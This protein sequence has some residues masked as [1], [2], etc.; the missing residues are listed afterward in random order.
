MLRKG[1]VTRNDRWELHYGDCLKDGILASMPDES[2]HSV[3]LDGPYGFDPKKDDYQ[4]GD[5][6]PATAGEGSWD[7][8]D[9]RRDMSDAAQADDLTEA[10]RL[11]N[12]LTRGVNYLD[13]GDR[14][15]TDNETWGV[16]SVVG[17]YAAEKGMVELPRYIMPPE[18]MFNFQLWCAEWAREDLRLLKP[19]GFLLAF[20]STKCYHRQAVGIEDAGFEVRD[21]IHWIYGQG[22]PKGTMAWKAYERSSKAPAGLK[23]KKKGTILTTPETDEGRALFGWHTG[24][25]PG[26]EPIVVAR[27]PFKGTI[28]GNMQAHGTGAFN[29][30]GCAVPGG[31]DQDDRHPSNVIVTHSPECVKGAACVPWCPVPQMEARFAGASGYF[32]CLYWEP[33]EW[34]W[35]VASRYVPKPGKKE[36]GAGREHP[37]VKPVALMKELTR[38]VTPRGGRVLDHFGGSGTTGVAAIDEGFYP[39]LVERAPKYLRIIQQRCGSAQL[40]LFK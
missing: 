9:A 29:I 22:M 34:E 23:A 35:Q 17:G 21:M 27:K 33:G 30:E 2:V 7:Q 1:L 28:Y 18:A 32:K 14:L 10:E 26:H 20:C 5:D 36:K 31:L 12:R 15:T 25:K 19:G 24:L 8:A 3:V 11:R 37:T 13:G 38:L 6:A 39:V 40:P 16:D 4:A